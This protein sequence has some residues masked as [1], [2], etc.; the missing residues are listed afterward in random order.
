MVRW[1][2]ITLQLGESHLALGQY[3]QGENYLEEAL[4]QPIRVPLA[5]LPG[6]TARAQLAQ[7]AEKRGDSKRADRFGARSKTWPW[8]S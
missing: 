2:E 8:P 4:A 1:R 5:P 7:S 3:R 6:I